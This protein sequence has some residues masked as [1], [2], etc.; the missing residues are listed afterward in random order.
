MSDNHIRIY[1][2]NT[3]SDL[4]KTSWCC[5]ELI[6]L[7]VNSVGSSNSIAAKLKLCTYA[8]IIY[9][10]CIIYMYIMPHF[11]EVTEHSKV[12][13]NCLTQ[14]KLSNATEVLKTIKASSMLSKYTNKY[15][16]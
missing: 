14:Y 13:K 3:Q 7:K 15:L 16:D 1:S 8:Y 11:I 12:K 9:K 5:S 10:L 2:H 6:I 4:P